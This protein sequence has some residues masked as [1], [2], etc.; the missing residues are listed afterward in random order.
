MVHTRLILNVNWLL[1][2]SLSSLYYKWLRITGLVPQ[3]FPNMVGHAVYLSK[4]KKKE[5]FSP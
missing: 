3:T 1:N 2:I 4:K 5:S